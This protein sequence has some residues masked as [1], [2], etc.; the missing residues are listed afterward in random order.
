VDNLHVFNETFLHVYLYVS[1]LYL[2]LHSLNNYKLKKSV[3][4]T[5]YKTFKVKYSF[6]LSVWTNQTIEVIAMNLEQAKQKARE[7]IIGA[8]GSEHCKD[9]IIH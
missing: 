9:L 2:Y 6:S 4:K 8:Y 1:K 3:M 7:E 5:T